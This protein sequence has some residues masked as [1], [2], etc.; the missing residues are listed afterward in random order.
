MTYKSC[1]ASGIWLV[2]FNDIL[3]KTCDFYRG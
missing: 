3:W 2:Q 1:R